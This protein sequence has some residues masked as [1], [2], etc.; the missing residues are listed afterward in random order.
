MGIDYGSK[1][2][3]L[4]VSDIEG[5]IA[6]PREVVKNESDKT[7]RYIVRFCDV[8]KIGAIVLGQS[9]DYKGQPN[10]IQ[11]AIENCKLKIAKLTHLPVYYQNEFFTSAQAARLTDVAKLDA[12]AAALILQSWLDHFAHERR[13]V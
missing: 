2:I 9:M 11:S 8:E 13:G 12:S 5:K 10:P 4:A 7:L 1:R 6:F 3:G